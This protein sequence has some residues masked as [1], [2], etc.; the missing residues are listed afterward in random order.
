MELMEVDSG[1][2]AVGESIAG[3]W[4]LRARLD[5]GSRSRARVEVSVF[6]GAGAELWWDRGAGVPGVFR[7]ASCDYAVRRPR[8]PFK[9]SVYGE[10]MLAGCM[11]GQGEQEPVFIFGGACGNATDVA[12][13]A[14]S[15]RVVGR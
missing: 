12:T 5:I 8:Q 4:E 1:R 15:C 10:G 7:P 2:S 11:G 14:A 13:D 9:T 3:S 6:L